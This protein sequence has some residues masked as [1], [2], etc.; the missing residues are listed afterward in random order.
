MDLCKFAVAW[1][2]FRHVQAEYRNVLTQG[3]GRHAGGARQVGKSTLAQSVTAERGG[4]VLHARRR[5]DARYGARRSGGA[6][7]RHTG[8]HRI[9][10]AHSRGISP[11]RRGRNLHDRASADSAV[12]VPAQTWPS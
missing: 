10:F 7:A 11:R 8:P 9:P 4:A 1:L 12:V 6:R 3:A 5:G 2:T